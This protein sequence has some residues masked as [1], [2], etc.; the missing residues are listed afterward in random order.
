MDP[1]TFNEP[2]IHL[3]V[4][5]KVVCSLMCVQVHRGA[6]WKT[7]EGTWTAAAAREF[8]ATDQQKADR[9]NPQTKLFYP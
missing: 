8:W 1:Q 9:A 6:D 7:E 3:D 4:G 2:W 5:T